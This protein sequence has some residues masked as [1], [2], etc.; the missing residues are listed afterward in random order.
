MTFV[1][2]ARHV[3]RSPAAV[4][5]KLHELGLT[6]RA[7]RFTDNK[8]DLLVIDDVIKHQPSTLA[9]LR[10]KTKIPKTTL[11]DTLDRLTMKGL[12]FKD[13]S[14][15]RTKGRPQVYYRII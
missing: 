12:L 6:S 13:T 15:T 9:E 8:T 3:L 2:V 14:L 7:I 1:E 5:A 11:Y 10:E 4:T